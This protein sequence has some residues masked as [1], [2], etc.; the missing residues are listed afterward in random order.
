[1]KEQCTNIY[2]LSKTI[3]FSLL[4]VGK[5]EENFNKKKMLQNDKDS[6]K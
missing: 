5:T 1:M 3:G 6:V 2:S 4:P